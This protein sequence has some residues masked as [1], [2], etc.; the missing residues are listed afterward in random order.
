MTERKPD[1]EGDERGDIPSGME[2]ISVGL[3]C[4]MSDADT[5]S[6]VVMWKQMQI[7]N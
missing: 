6:E 3:R 5:I 1:Q 7:K 4:Q 2:P